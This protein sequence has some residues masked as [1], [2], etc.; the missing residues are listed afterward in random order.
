[1]AESTVAGHVKASDYVDRINNNLGLSFQRM[2]KLDSARYCF[3]QVL[4]AAVRKGNKEYEANALLNIANI[5]I[6]F[7]EYEQAEQNLRRALSIYAETGN[8]NGMRMANTNLG[9]VLVQTERFDEA[10]QAFRDAEE[11]AVASGMP[12]SLAVIY[13]NEGDIYFKKGQYAESLRLLDKSLAIKEQYKDSMG[14]ARSYNAK[15]GVYN[16]LRQYDHSLTYASDAMGIARR[17]DNVDLM[18]DIY[19]NTLSALVGQGKWNEAVET[20]DA[21]DILRDSVFVKEK[22]AAI[23]ELK[24]KYETEQKE[25][26][27]ETAHKTIRQQKIMSILFLIACVSLIALFFIYY[28]FQRKKRQDHI[29]IVKQNEELS[30]YIG[31]THKTREVLPEDSD[32][33]KAENGNGVRHL[34]E[35][36]SGLEQ[37]FDHEKIY[38]TQG[39]NINVVADK[40]ATNRD[41]LSKV[42]NSSLGKGFN[43]YVN[44]YRIEEAKEIL[45]AQCNG[46]HTAYTMQQIAEKVGFAGT[47]PFYTAFKQIVGVTPGE[48]KKTLKHIKQ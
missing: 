41:Y 18:I 22:F 29:R 35:I 32:T 14:L 38:R 27:L 16:R 17:A 26:K 48:Y 21:R 39:L 19:G 6:R 9:T 33:G 36:L 43:E 23:Q 11:I 44:F 25:Q 37:L 3:E 28:Y 47:S 46:Q 5:L 24:V 2:E 8:K 7:K 20:L 15:A 31:R 13:H 34:A 12:A 30:E 42:I 10:L 1:M 40:L 4:N 45:K